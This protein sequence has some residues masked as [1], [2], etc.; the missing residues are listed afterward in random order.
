M[1]VHS[2]ALKI[3]FYPIL[4]PLSSENFHLGY[5][6]VNY[7][8]HNWNAIINVLNGNTFH[9][10]HVLNRAQLLDDSFNLAKAGYLDFSIA[11]N[12][13]TKY[14]HREYELMPITD[15]FRTIEFLLTYLDEQPF[16]A[17]LLDILQN[18]LDEIYVRVNNA[19]HPEHPR[20]FPDNY[21]Q[22]IKL[23]V[24]LFACKFGAFACIVDAR[25][26]MF[27]YDLVIQQPTADERQYLY[28]GALNG[29]LATSQW[30]KLKGRLADITKDIEIYR[31][32]QDEITD[33]LYA[34][35]NC[36]DD[37][38]RVELLLI[39]IFN[40]SQPFPYQLIS[41]ED[42][43][44]VIGN[45]IKVGS[46]HRELVMEFYSDHYELVNGR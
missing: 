25:S 15:G 13:L 17:D 6:R 35:S 40:K 23:K 20:T 5:Y 22:L 31:D 18:V 43:T 42:A 33:I 37:M 38:E 16:Y 21:H 24:N 2:I 10:V 7:N 1:E 30:T 26:E 14:L 27:L 28:C 8:E 4:I 3:T 44:Y 9:I 34:F 32:N 11:L 19:S 12:L 46:K 36:D 29:D 39:D 45:L 41:K